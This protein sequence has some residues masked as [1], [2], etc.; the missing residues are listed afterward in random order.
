MYDIDGKSAL[1]TGGTRGIGLGI[2]RAVLQRGG[3]VVLNGRENTADA[4]ALVE[5]FGAERVAVELADV[6]VPE[7]AADLVGRRS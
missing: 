3:N 5:E 2:A 7:Q 6:S 4:D 1:I